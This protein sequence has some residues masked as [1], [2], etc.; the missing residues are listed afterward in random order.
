M[1]KYPVDR[2]HK[3]LFGSLCRGIKVESVSLSN[4]VSHVEKCH[5]EVHF[6]HDG[7]TR[8]LGAYPLSSPLVNLDKH[9]Y[10]LL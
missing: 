6:M 2:G 5:G 10:T 1:T 8:M 7:H 9:T 4:P 3:F